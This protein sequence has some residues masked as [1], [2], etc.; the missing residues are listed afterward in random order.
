MESRRYGLHDY[1]NDH[2]AGST[3]ISAKAESVFF[4]PWRLFYFKFAPFVFGSATF[5]K[6][7][8]LRHRI[9]NF[10]QLLEEESEPGMNH[11]FLELLN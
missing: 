3:R 9:Q 5:L 1:K 11:W 8:I 6:L 10:L 2:V 7:L 4:T